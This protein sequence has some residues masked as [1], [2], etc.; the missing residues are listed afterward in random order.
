VNKNKKIHD[1][2]LAAVAH[3]MHG[4]TATSSAVDNAVL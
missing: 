4:T 1:A 2:Q 3:I